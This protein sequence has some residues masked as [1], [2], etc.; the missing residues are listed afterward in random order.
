MHEKKKI[1]CN[2]AGEL[3][4]CS[5]LKDNNTLLIATQYGKDFER[6]SP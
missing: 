4:I 2:F 5:F 6:G 1:F 3:Q